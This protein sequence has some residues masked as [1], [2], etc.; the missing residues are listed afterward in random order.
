MVHHL[1]PKF[2]DDPS[3]YRRA[4][5]HWE[6]FVDQAAKEAGQQGEWR[7]WMV[8]SFADGT[9]LPLDGNP[10]FE[11]MSSRLNRALRVVQ[12][13]PE[14]DE[15]EIVAYLDRA[16]GEDPENTPTADELV[17]ALALSEETKSIAE[18]L[19]RLWMNAHTTRDQMA[20]A[21]AELTALA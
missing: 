11:A 9:A 3:E 14:R 13:P 7:S 19:V 5:A 20:G 15:P 12:S 4:Q 21:I 2:L 17:I 16:G 8:K 6:R 1:F 10:I 18:R